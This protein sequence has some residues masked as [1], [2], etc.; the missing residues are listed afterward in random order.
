MWKVPVVPGLALLA[1]VMLPGGMSAQERAHAAMTLTAQDRAEMQQ[2]V[3][4][5][6]RAL[7]T[8]DAVQYAELFAEPDGFFASGPRGH[9]AGRDRLVAL[10]ESERHCN[11]ATRER[12]PINVPADVSFEPS[13]EGAVG[14]AVLGPN[15]NHYEDA[16]VKTPKGWRFKS[17]TF[18]SAQEEAAGLTGQDFVEIRR[19]AGNDAGQFADVYETTPQGRRFRSSGVVIRVSDAGVTGRAALKNGGGYY[20]DVYVKAPTGWRFTSRTYSAARD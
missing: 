8:C 14:R 7:G 1:S 4:G 16:Y 13:P 3:A 2:L 19:L 17:R 12:Q 11:D 5:Y 18:V 9:V 15:G 10:V 6:S 20:D